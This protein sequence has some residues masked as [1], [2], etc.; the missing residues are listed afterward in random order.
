MKIN[1]FLIDIRMGNDAF[2]KQ[3]YDKAVDLYNKAIDTIRDSPVLY[4][5]RALTYI[6]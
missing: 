4:C 1:K 6:K 3:N 2:K 5:N